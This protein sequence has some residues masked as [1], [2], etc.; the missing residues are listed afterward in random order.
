VADPPPNQQVVLTNLVVHHFDPGPS[1]EVDLSC[2]S[3][4]SF[5]LRYV[6]ITAIRAG[7]MTNQPL[8]G[9]G[10]VQ[11]GSGAPIVIA[12]YRQYVVVPE[13]GAFR[14]VASLHLPAGSWAVIGKIVVDDDWN[15]TAECDLDV[16][17]DRDRSEISL[18]V[19]RPAMTMAV[20]VTHS[21][22]GAG[23][24][25]AVVRCAAADSSGHSMTVT[26]I[27]IVAVKAGSLTDRVQ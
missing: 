19:Y 25:N 4:E 5:Q 24:A 11:V 1:D 2:E 18:G 14:T 7:S 23:G 9:S 26:N 15:A 22:V 21:I 20:S 27:K 8:P 12:G 16:G 17:T 10:A 13:G 3:S 6:K